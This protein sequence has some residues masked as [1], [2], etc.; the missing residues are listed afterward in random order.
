MT[1][2]EK[3]KYVVL[4]KID[5]ER[6]RKEKME[7]FAYIVRNFSENK[8]RSICGDESMDAEHSLLS[9]PDLNPNPMDFKAEAT[10][11]IDSNPN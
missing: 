4:A 9:K 6:A 10:E 3:H 7:Y 1:T 2:T 8:A 11:P 5:R